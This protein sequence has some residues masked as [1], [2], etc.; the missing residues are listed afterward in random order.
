MFVLLHRHVGLDLGAQE[1]AQGDAGARHGAVLAS[2]GLAVL[3]GAQQRLDD[4]KV[5]RLQ[6]GVADLH[7][8]HAV[9]LLALRRFHETFKERVRIGTRSKATTNLPCSRM[10]AMP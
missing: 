9:R 3:L 8:V 5:H 1:A 6:R 7:Q 10:S 4:A 2:P